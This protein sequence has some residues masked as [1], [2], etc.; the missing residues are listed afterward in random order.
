MRMQE[1]WLQLKGLPGSQSPGLQAP[2]DLG[3]SCHPKWL[4]RNPN[5]CHKLATGP[6]HDHVRH[7]DR[8]QELLLEL[9][10]RLERVPTKTKTEM[11]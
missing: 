2:E 6:L 1:W 4:H 9:L 11:Y 10:M 7:L 3:W 5:L 8:Y